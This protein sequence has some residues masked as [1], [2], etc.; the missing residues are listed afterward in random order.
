MT[1]TSL[2]NMEKA[3]HQRVYGERSNLARAISVINAC[4]KRLASTAAL[5]HSLV[6]DP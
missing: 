2:E 4:A 3:G 6:P 5:N 1:S